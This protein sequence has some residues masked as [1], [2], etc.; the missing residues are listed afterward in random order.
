M[1]SSLLVLCMAIMISS[2]YVYCEEKEEEEEGNLELITGMV[3][4]VKGEK[5]EIKSCTIAVEEWD[6]EHIKKNIKIYNVKLDE[7]GKKFAIDMM[8]KQVRAAGILSTIENGDKVENFIKIKA[9]K[10]LI[11]DLLATE[12]KKKQK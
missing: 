3:K 12:G 7:L 10:E 4:T 2:N 8:G 6:K 1:K 5:G 9:Y 11:E